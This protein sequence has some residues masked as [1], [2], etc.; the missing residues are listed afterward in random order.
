[1][2]LVPIVQYTLPFS[3]TTGQSIEW[4]IDILRTYNDQN[5]DGSQRSNAE[6]AAFYDWIDEVGGQLV[7]PNVVP[8]V[9]SSNPIE[10]E[11]ERD[12]N[13]YKPIIGS[14]ANI[15]L[16]VQTA[17]QYADF[18]T[19]SQYEYQVRVRYADANNAMQDYW[20]GYMTSLD[21]K[22]DVS[23]FPFPISF[24]ATDGLGLLE[25]ATAPIPTSI[26]EVNVIDAITGALYQTGLNLDIYVDSGIQI[27]DGATP[28]VYSEALRQVTIDPDW[29]YNEQ[30]TERLTLKEEIEGILSAF[31]C[32]IKQS[33]GKW[34]I[35]NASTYG[36]VDDDATFEVYNVV[37][38]VY[39]KNATDATETVRYTIDGSDTASLIPANQD[40]VLNTRR[41]YGSIEC[42]P[43]GFYSE[44]VQNGG[45]E[46]VDGNGVPD[47]W[48][49]GPTEGPLKTSDTIRQSGERS[50]FT[51]H[52][53]FALDT[54]NDTWFTNT[55]GID[56]DGSGTFE[57]SFD[58]LAELLITEGSNGVR[59]AKL[60]Y[61]VIFV[62][63]NPMTLGGLSLFNPLNLF[64]VPN[65]TANAYFYNPERGEWIGSSTMSTRYGFDLNVIEAEGDDV[66]EWL[67]ASV[68]MPKVRVW[69]Y[70]LNDFGETTVGAGKLFIRFYFPRGNRPQGNGKSQN[71]GNGNDRLRVYV[72]NV[73]AKNMFSNDITD[74]TFERVQDNYTSTYTYEPGI[75]SSTSDA[76]IQTVSQKDFIRTGSGIDIIL[77]K[78]LEEIGTQ[79]KLNDFRNS[80]KYYEGSLVNLTAVPLAP[81][82]KVYV[83][84]SN[85]TETASCII[86]GGRFDV[87][88]NQFSVAMYVPDQ[89]SDIAPDGFFPY[90]VD[91]IP[92]PF[93][94]I[95]NK[96]V[97]SLN[98]VVNETRDENNAIVANGLVPVQASHQWT[99][100]PGDEIP[101]EIYFE[102]VSGMD[103][104]SGASV[105][106]EPVHLTN[107]MYSIIGEQL[108]VNAT[109]VIPEDSE[110]ETLTVDGRIEESFRPETPAVIIPQTI[111][112]NRPVDSNVQSPTG[113]TVTLINPSTGLTNTYVQT[114]VPANGFNGDY[115]RIIYTIEAIEGRAMTNVQETH[116][117]GELSIGVVAG[118]EERVATITFDYRVPAATTPL[119]VFLDGTT[120]NDNTGTVPLIT[121]TLT[122]TNSAADT[123][124]ED[125]TTS[126]NTTTLDFRGVVGDFRRQNITVQPDGDKYIRTLFATR[127]STGTGSLTV[128]TPYESGE[129]WEIPIIVPIVDDDVQPSMSIT[130]VTNEEPY[131][132][133]FNVNNLGMNNAQIRMQDV[134]H[135]ITY[136]EG[137][138]GVSFPRAGESITVT[139]EP[140][141]NHKFEAGTD[142]AVDINESAAALTVNGVTNTRQLPELQFSPGVITVN[143]NGSLTFPITG[144]FPTIE[145]GGGQYTLDINVMSNNDVGGPVLEDATIGGTS[146][147]AITEGIGLNGGIAQFRVIAD[148]AWKIELDITNGGIRTVTTAEINETYNGTGSNAGLSYNIEGSMGP[149]TG[150]AGEHLVSL[151]LGPMQYDSDL[152]NGMLFTPGFF[153]ISFR[154]Y[155]RKAS[156][157]ALRS[158]TMQQRGE[159]GGTNVVFPGASPVFLDLFSRR[160][161]GENIIFFG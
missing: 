152:P 57:V 67:R 25:Q 30:R 37:T 66:G 99:A 14:K 68:T 3:T 141:G 102:P 108:R 17:G 128:G 4:E 31:N 139:V 18:N 55:T 144:T 143:S 2:A 87:K 142:I 111:L 136:D 79:L 21:G 93:P 134:Q 101:V 98:V 60:S 149:I 145:E 130:G 160:P 11:W 154:M 148:G 137:D 124:V 28:V 72:D 118:N 8:L 91:L 34:Y 159:Y 51:N 45:F 157:G 146:I 129:D 1:M 153:R 75:A 100:S 53:T 33:A 10:I 112:F 97:Y 38:N 147:E 58:M 13:V 69:D 52:N 65:I 155:L 86:N 32:T 24:T 161:G 50:I 109:L 138:F 41:P 84:W 5:P 77:N 46:V 62:P 127:T 12:Y 110:F 90:N 74:P 47:G 9:G 156:G 26:T 71:R 131:S 78:S 125:G 107:I 27:G 158:A 20:C 150:T 82:H 89:S 36:G 16:L 121:K 29:V 44:D 88:G 94:G 35:T 115:K 80:F 42:K 116:N 59:N 40:L 106:P 95:S 7:F 56:V 123:T 70:T 81:H 43:K 61:Q 140:I 122:V 22:E 64:T 19:A 15:N 119:S 105:L 113:S 63:D 103:A 120:T 48:T 49:S 151:N 135:K 133:T 117:G 92:M 76:L 104:V 114:S 54:V 126:G 132:L 83:N 6:I 96:R 85:Y 73:S 23:T 39:V